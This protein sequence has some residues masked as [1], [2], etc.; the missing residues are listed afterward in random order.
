MVLLKQNKRLLTVLALLAFF[1]TL[2]SAAGNDEPPVQKTILYFSRQLDSLEQGF[3]AYE[4][5]AKT[6]SEE[7]IRLQFKKCRTYYKRIE[8]LVE[9]M[10]PA[11]ALRINGAALLEADAAEP[12][13]PTY[14]TG[15]QVLE[16]TVFD[17]ITTEAR[18]TMAGELSYAI[19]RVR[20][21]K[22]YRPTLE[23]D[24]A[25][26]FDALRLNIYRML[27]KGISGFDSPGALNSMPEAQASLESTKEILGYYNAPKA[28]LV[29]CSDAIAYTK[30]PVSFNDFDRAAFIR[31]HINPL[32]AELHSF[33]LAK[34]IPFV[35][36]QRALNTDAKNFFSADAFDMYYFAPTGT[37]PASPEMIALGKKLFNEPMLSANE[38]RSCGSCHEAKK[39]FTDGLALNATLSGNG[40]L[41]RNTPTLINASLQPVQ[42]YDSRIAFLEDQVHDV[43]SNKQEMGG[44]L[45]EVVAKLKKDKTYQQ[46]F[47]ASFSNDD[48]AVSK[49]NIKLALAAYV[50]SLTSLNA[51]FDKYM[52][53]DDKA[54]NEQELLGFN[55]FMGKAKCGTCHYVP[56]FN[57]AVPPLYDKV[58]SEVLGVPSNTDTLHPILD[59]DSG[60]YN[61][62]KMP[63]QVRSFKTPGLRN[64]AHTAPY[65]HNGVYKTLEEV[66][67]FY[68]RG[69][70]AG[71]GLDVPN[72]TLPGDRLGLTPQE[73]KA[74]ISFLKSLSDTAVSP[75]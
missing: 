68:D 2:V 44:D 8:F 47:K 53:G 23:L 18:M 17:D 12:E 55:L 13:E 9:Y 61:L 29:K 36:Q 69:G 22:K 75:S 25:M 50:R 73:K 28:L 65:M 7:D 31:R 37:K 3:I 66:I 52:R 24:D 15:F 62:Y 41:L 20:K 74:L 38:K 45:S 5:I 60:K 11:A 19:N 63:H 34:G 46:D 1:I 42:F 70:G 40:Q 32:L 35:Q 6:G 49:K 27:A 58:E 48:D 39:A 43:V 67:D 56:L 10:Y 14:P 33:Q 57:G 51:P 26:V 21:L 4:Q 30:L 64:V 59:A 16:E 72:Q 71:L 54:M